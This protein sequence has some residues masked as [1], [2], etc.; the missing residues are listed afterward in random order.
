[1]TMEEYV[2]RLKLMVPINL[3]EMVKDWSVSDKMYFFLHHLEIE[4]MHKICKRLDDLEK[5]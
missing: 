4:E 2:E 5:K 3:V 1:M